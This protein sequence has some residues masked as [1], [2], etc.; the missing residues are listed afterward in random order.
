RLEQR[1]EIPPAPFGARRRTLAGGVPP[2]QV[3]VRGQVLMPP[4][5]ERGGF[6]EAVARRMLRAAGRNRGGASAGPACG[7]E[8]GTTVPVLGPAFRGA[9]NGVG[10]P[11]AL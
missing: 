2:G 7:R 6:L 10:A 11:P 9:S 5:G 1:P 4:G 3:V 8:P